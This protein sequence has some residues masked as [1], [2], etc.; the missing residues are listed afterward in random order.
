M[1]GGGT[2]FIETMRTARGTVGADA[3][4]GAAAH[5]PATPAKA[6]QP[7][8]QVTLELD[9][10][11]GA[12]RVRVAIRGDTVHATIIAAD[13]NVAA[14]NDQVH[15]LR[16]ALE[17]RGFAEAHVAVRSPDSAAATT[18][19]VGAVGSASAGELRASAGQDAGTD[20]HP[21]QHAAREQ[22]RDPAEQRSPR[23]RPRHEQE[24]A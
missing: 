24:M 16:R 13:G 19:T 9:P 17:S 6:M 10:A 4:P 3:G 14:L 22:Y 7:S 11:M 23:R 8:S 2:T 18:T 15:E 1:V 5:E 12:G 21:D 20:A